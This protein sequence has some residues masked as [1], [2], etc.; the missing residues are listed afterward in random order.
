MKLL[1]NM[2]YFPDIEMRWDLEILID[3]NVELER[4]VQ[5]SI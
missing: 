5:R 4:K 3:M 2:K 1:F